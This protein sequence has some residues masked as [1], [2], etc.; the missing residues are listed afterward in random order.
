MGEEK[1]SRAS[2]KEARRSRTGTETEPKT[3]TRCRDGKA[4]KG[5]RKC[6]RDRRKVRKAE[7]RTAP[8]LWKCCAMLSFERL[9]TLT[10]QQA[11]P[12][13]STVL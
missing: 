2:E 5:K 13:G 11:V 12:H 9:K 3:G 10:V 6:Q 7:K 4:Q 1:H 8:L